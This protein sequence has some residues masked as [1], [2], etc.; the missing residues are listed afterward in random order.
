MRRVGDAGAFR[1]LC[2]PGFARMQ[3][4][5]SL[6][7][8][9]ICLVRLMS[10]KD[11]NMS[12]IPTFNRPFATQAS[13]YNPIKPDELSNTTVTV[14][15]IQLTFSHIFTTLHKNTL[16][17]KQPTSPAHHLRNGSPF[18]PRPPLL[19]SHVCLITEV[20]PLPRR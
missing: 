8:V 5:A 11:T 17:D 10:E 16:H 6:Y 18:F 9:A 19:H 15:Y 12:V 13:S 14:H 4:A 1:T 2:Q 20:L 3:S 7:S